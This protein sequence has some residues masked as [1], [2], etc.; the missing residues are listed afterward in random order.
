LEKEL[1][2]GKGGKQ[3]T[4]DPF[5]TAS[6]HETQPNFI[7]FTIEQ[8]SL[9]VCGLGCS[10]WLNSPTSASGNWEMGFLQLLWLCRRRFDVTLQATWSLKTFLAKR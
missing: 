4:K 7:N 9:R 8:L 6:F 5:G 1:E 10:I 3:N 2:K